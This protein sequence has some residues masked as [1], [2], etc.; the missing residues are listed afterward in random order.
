MKW[1]D[2]WVVSGSSCLFPSCSPAH[3]ANLVCVKILCVGQEQ[4]LET[5]VQQRILADGV[6]LFPIP[7]CEEGQY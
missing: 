5:P 3:F 1:A 4:L 7:D 6:E 2:S